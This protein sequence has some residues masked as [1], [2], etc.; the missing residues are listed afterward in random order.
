MPTPS[1]TCS[2]LHRHTFVR[3]IIMGLGIFLLYACQ[4]EK[5]GIPPFKVA[6]LSG[7]TISQNDL[8]DKVA[9]INFWAT[10][11]AVCV[12]EMPEMIHT[13][14]RHKK[15]GLVFIAVAMAYDPPMYVADF[16]KTRKLPFI[17]AMDS[18]G[19]MAQKFGKIEFTPTT[20][21]INKDGKIIKRYVG[22]PNW[23]QLNAL[24][25]KSLAQKAKDSI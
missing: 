23:N 15:D 24:L 11:C 17:V 3:I 16:T 7:K 4:P 19:R 9:I 20:L 12:K 21:V 22:E 14:E 8:K 5:A 6:E 13:Y 18:D 25:E 1:K 2:S 10:T